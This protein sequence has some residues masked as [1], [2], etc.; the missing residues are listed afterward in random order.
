MSG[1]IYRIVTP[2][3]WT[4]MQQTE[5]LPLS[6]IDIRDGYIHLSCKEQ[7]LSTANRYFH[8]FQMLWVLAYPVV[9][10]GSALKM[11]AVPEREGEKFPHFYGP[12]LPLEWVSTAYIL[13]REQ[14]VFR[15]LET[16]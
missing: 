14:G 15:G 7:V 4:E 10:L 2:E 13:R 6:E 9:T 3:Q 12:A 16:P 11:E 1:F 5:R 8:S